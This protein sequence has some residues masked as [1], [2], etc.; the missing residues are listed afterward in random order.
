MSELIDYSA[1]L[2]HV[3][4]SIGSNVGNLQQ[5][6]EKAIDLLS[7][8]EIIVEINKSSYYLTEPFGYDTENWFLNV[9][10]QGKTLLDPFLL[11]FNLKSIEYQLGRKGKTELADRIIDIDIL[12]YD[13]LTI[14]SKYLTLPHP[15]LQ[16]RNFMLLP[17]VE[18]LPNLIHP[19]LNKSLQNVLTDCKDT[20]KVIKQ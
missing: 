10:I 18:I 14:N 7:K 1:S 17:T 15:R 16:T 12:F 2:H 19:T 11:L 5:N 13:L 20:L 3:V 9:S 6:I 4:L 8:T